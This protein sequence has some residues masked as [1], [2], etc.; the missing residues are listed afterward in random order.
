MPGPSPGLRR[1]L[2]GL[3][4]A[5]G[6]G[7][8]GLSGKSPLLLGVDR[9]GAELPDLSSGLTPLPAP[10]SPRS[11]ASAP[12]LEPLSPSPHHAQRPSLVTPGPP[13]PFEMEGVLLHPTL[14]PRDPVALLSL[15]R[16]P[17]RSVWCTVDH[18]LA[19][20]PLTLSKDPISST[21]DSEALFPLH[22]EPWQPGR[23]RGSFQAS[24]PASSFH[25]LYPGLGSSR[26]LDSGTTQLC[27]H[28][29]LSLL[30]ICQDLENSFIPHPP[31][32]VPSSQRC[33]VHRR[34]HF[35]SLPLP[36]C[37]PTT[38]LEPWRP[39]LTVAMS[40]RHPQGLDSGSTHPNLRPGQD[41]GLLAVAQEP[42]WADLQPRVALVERG[43]SLWLNCS[44]NCP[45][46]ERGGLETSLRR[47]G[48]QRGL[49]WLARQLVDIR[50]PETQPVC[51][52]RCARRTLQAR[53]LIRTFQR[54]DRVELVPLPAWQPVGENF[55][56]SCRVPGA[57][58][59]GSLTLTLLRGAQELIRRNFA[60]EPPRARG[61]VL[62]ATVL[63]RR[64][65]HGANFSCRAELDLRPH[66][67]G[68]FENSS[69]PRELRTFALS[70][71]SPR[72]IAP[73]LLE[74]G[75]EKPVS[76]SLDGLFPAPEA[77]V[78]LELGD[79]RLNPYVT[80]EGDAL[81]ATA[82]VTASAEQEGARQLV[83]TVTL[84]GESRETREN[85][86]IYSF[87]APLL[88]LSEPNAPEGKMVTVTCT[89][90]ARTLVALEG[91][92]AAVLGQPAQLQ[93][94]VTENDDRRGFFCEA[95]LEVDGEILSKNESAELRVLYGPRL[96]DSDCP[97]SWTWPEGPE[98]TLRC[99]AR[100]NPAPSVHCARPDGGA[101]LALGLLGPVTRALAGTY[102]CTAVN[103]QGEAVKDVTLTVE[104]APAL[105]SV[106]CPEQIT[107]LEGTEASLSCVAHG[108]PPPNVSCVRTGEAKI[109]E[110]LLRVAREHAGTYRCEAT[111]ARGSAA[112]NV[113]VTV[114]YGPS[115]DELSCPSNW[116]WVQ[117][118]GRLFSCDVEGKPEPNVECVGSE[119][120]SEGT[121]L[122]LASS[123]PNPRDPAIASD[124]TPGIYIC[125]AT[126][127][128]GSTVKTVVVSAE[129]ER[130]PASPQMDESTC[131]SHQTWLEGAKP[132]AL[133]C[134]ARGQPFP[135]VHCSREG[136]PQPERQRVS[137][138]DAGTYL[139]VA[140]N[141]HGTD[142]R[143]ITV[144]VEY[145]PVVAELAA[146]PSS[147]RPGGNFT[148]T[149][150][151]EAW[152]PAQI[153][154]RA[155]PGALNIGL[156]SN[157]ST[158]SVAGAMGSHGGEY[159]CA[160]TNA[161]GRHARRITVRVAGPWLW[162]AVG[163]AAGGAALLAAGA[164][165]AFYVQSTAC[166]K[167]E[168][169][170]Q[171]AESSGEAVCLNGAGGGAG[172]SA[173]GGPETGGS[174]ESPSGG[175]V[176]AIQL[177]SA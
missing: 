39:G 146:S 116:T 164:G 80:L 88:N 165:L 43:G 125:N 87:P 19:S 83:C 163:G 44:T 37:F 156:S 108:V 89:A 176:F 171:E 48:T 82:T 122:P 60:G 51:F 103:V 56:L 147:V 139:C 96:D 45:R 130:S 131:P 97:R 66:G 169:N 24:S 46:P 40:Q 1:A 81:M 119:G 136:A 100:G 50:E 138:E 170:V 161:H 129:C 35:P 55:T 94:N 162:V 117:G 73:R 10:P 36:S 2:L 67:L 49:R 154:W 38:S 15:P 149:C 105:D 110:G 32:G 151:A 23:S 86:T 30:A 95:I 72:L 128:H 20:F 78:Y 112:K 54:P 62:T 126:N 141:A 63:A 157:N 101:V 107:W 153:S 140:T 64:E 17:P 159:E 14:C 4:A 145:R 109:V 118:S 71:D 142:S 11:H 160:A 172:G 31:P 21:H 69:A 61:A 166:K 25:I 133:A 12:H 22:S 92:P 113:A 85:L 9:A 177:T 173:E 120:A 134:T 91:I 8:L 121:V 90:G 53:G 75:S 34:P 144:G 41:A 3:W 7:I 111:N 57:G 79:Q 74:V 5:L 123:N 84:G 174:A 70:P 47:N 175:E 33:C 143:T 155:P 13:T 132:A 124:L 42:F 29:N 167:G 152:P 58:P 65:D 93:L 27:P 26:I 6:L 18:G 28:S 106:G 77:G 148:L 52:F 68:L 104:Y 127:R 135:Q 99:E 59:R 158:L 150:R 76:C 115:F 137:R 114:E 16:V 168:Y 98:Q 102:R